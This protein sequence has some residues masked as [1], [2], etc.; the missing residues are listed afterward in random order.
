MFISVRDESTLAQKLH[1]GDLKSFQWIYENYY[2]IL[3]RFAFRFTQDH[4]SA[5]EIVDDVMFSLWDHHED[6]VITQFRPYLFRAVRNLCIN[7]LK[8]VAVRFYSAKNIS[9]DEDEKFLNS[10]FQNDEHPLGI[11]LEKELEIH[12]QQAIHELPAECRRVFLMSRSECLTYEEIAQELG[13]S[14]NTVKYH[15]KNALRILSKEMGRY[16]ILLLALI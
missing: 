8:S 14:V 6:V 12:F 15:M 3:C 9:I 2:E 5:E 1:E 4:G 13:I 7:H 11:L 10:L 16:L